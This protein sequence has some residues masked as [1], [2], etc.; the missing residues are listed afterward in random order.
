MSTKKKSR[1]PLFREKV[2][3]FS[4]ELTDFAQK[5][6]NTEPEAHNKHTDYKKKIRFHTCP[7]CEMKP[8]LDVI[9]MRVTREYLFPCICMEKSASTN[10]NK[11]ICCTETPARMISDLS[12]GHKVYIDMFCKISHVNGN[13]CTTKI[14]WKR[15]QQTT[16]NRNSQPQCDNIRITAIKKAFATIGSSS[17]GDIELHVTGPDL[18]KKKPYTR[19]GVGLNMI[20]R[21]DWRPG[22]L[23]MSTTDP[24]LQ[25]DIKLELSFPNLFE[26]QSCLLFDKKGEILLAWPKQDCPQEYETVFHI[27]NT[28]NFKDMVLFSKY[29]NILYHNDIQNQFVEMEEKQLKKKNERHVINVSESNYDHDSDLNMLIAGPVSLDFDMI[30]LRL[31]T[32]K[33]W[34]AFQSSDEI[35]STQDDFV[36]TDKYFNFETM[37]GFDSNVFFDESSEYLNN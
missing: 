23:F 29:D 7:K 15:I 25:A 30:D 22:F 16:W 31:S 1:D 33:E 28:S 27:K 4:K 19:L 18:V 2:T 10:T 26:D 35:Y 13:E 9:K 12:D 20:S 24:T 21:K 34:L 6:G 17:W 3:N 11:H 36:S 37:S 8:I 5:N 14:S 32:H